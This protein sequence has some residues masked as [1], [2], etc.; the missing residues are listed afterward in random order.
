MCDCL[1]NQKKV[2]DLPTDIQDLCIYA[3]SHRIK[4]NSNLKS[5][6]KQKSW[7]K[8]IHIS[9]CNAAKASLRNSNQDSQ[10]PGSLEVF[11]EKYLMNQ[12]I[13]KTILEMYPI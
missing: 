8:S 2:D 12:E 9:Y 6:L 4:T 13:G 1:E 5:S 7:L 3:T 11:Q 10:F